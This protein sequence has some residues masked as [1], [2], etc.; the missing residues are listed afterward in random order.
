TIR[1]VEPGDEIFDEMPIDASVRNIKMPKLR[2]E[3]KISI[4]DDAAAGYLT[5][6]ISFLTHGTQARSATVAARTQKA[7][8]RKKLASA[9]A[10]VEV[11]SPAKTPASLLPKAAARNQIPI[12]RPTSFSGA[13]LVIVLRPTGL[14]QSSPTVCRKNRPTTQKGLTACRTVSSAAGTIS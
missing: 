13:S 3:E 1:P 7:W 14:R 6:P 11:N 5:P 2:R 12:V 10:S 4:A 9:C 8:C